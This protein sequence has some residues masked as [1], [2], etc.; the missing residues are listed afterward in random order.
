MIQCGK[1]ML[2]FTLI[3]SLLLAY[4][5][6]AFA[7]K[8]CKSYLKK[9]HNVQ[10]MQRQSSSLKRSQS[11]RSREDKA[12]AIWWECENTSAAK[13]KAKYSKKK[14]KKKKVARKKSAKKS[15]KKRKSTLLLSQP[16]S[17]F[18]QGSSIVIKSKY[19]GDKQRAWLTFYEKP[20]QCKRPNKL[21]IFAYCH[22]DKIV[23]QGHFEQAYIK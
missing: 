9:L 2:I 8:R 4:S 15:Q 6:S 3:I 12:R 5:Q 21:S 18:N 23:Q 22:E 16:Q 14:S 11:L 13:F 20:E 19:Q 10:A 7:K 1:G 17:T